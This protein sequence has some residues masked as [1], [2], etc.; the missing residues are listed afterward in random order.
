MVASLVLAV[1][2]GP[3]AAQG[4]ATTTLDELRPSL[5]LEGP[6][7]AGSRAEDKTYS[8]GDATDPPGRELDA[9]PPPHAR[10]RGERG[11]H[12]LH[13]APPELRFDLG[14]FVFMRFEMKAYGEYSGSSQIEG[15]AKATAK[16]IADQLRPRFDQQGWIK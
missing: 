7:P 1:L 16:E 13:A 14:V 12:G 9:Q 3:A 2:E 11:K 15:R 6:R 10:A 5:T 8:A 4:S